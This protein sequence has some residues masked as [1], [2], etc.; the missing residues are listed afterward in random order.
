MHADSHDNIIRITN[1]LGPVNAPTWSPDGT[2]IAFYA[3]DTNNH[4]GI[5][6]LNITCALKGK[7]CA[8][9]PTFLTLGIEPD[10]SPDGKKIV[11]L[12]TSRYEVHV[13]DIQNLSQTVIVSHELG[14]CNSPQ[15]SPDGTKIALV[16]DQTIYTINPTSGHPINLVSGALYLR[17]K[18]DGGKIAFIGTE[19][20]DPGLGQSLDL[21]GTISATAVFVMDANGTNITRISKSNEEN[22]GWLTWILMN[23]TKEGH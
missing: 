7:D 21:E 15:W 17:W 5:Y 19:M 6:L 23:S 2:Q 14:R 16:C 9:N 3:P 18:P 4:H 20:L 22:I 12:N 11:Y 13:V 8:S 1:G 10:W